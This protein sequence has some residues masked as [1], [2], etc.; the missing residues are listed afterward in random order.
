M[1]Q[2]KRKPNAININ[3]LPKKSLPKQ[4]K[5]P[6]DF[7]KP[8]MKK[9]I[10]KFSVTRSTPPNTSNNNI[11]INTHNKTNTPQRII[12]KNTSSTQQPT[13]SAK[14]TYIP[15][16]NNTGVTESRKPPKQIASQIQEKP[17]NHSTYTQI[18]P[19][20]QT[21][22]PPSKNITIAERKKTP[23]IGS[24][25]IRSQTS[26]QNS[27]DITDDYII[28]PS[29][30]SSPTIIV[31]E[32]SYSSPSI[33]II[34]HIAQASPSTIKT[35][36]NAQHNNNGELLIEYLKKLFSPR[37]ITFDEKIFIFVEVGKLTDEQLKIFQNCVDTCQCNSVLNLPDNLNILL[38]VVM[39]MKQFP[40]LY[41]DIGRDFV[42][43]ININLLTND[44]SS[45][46]LDSTTTSSSL[47]QNKIYLKYNGYTIEGLEILKYI[48]EKF[49]L[50]CFTL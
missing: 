18:K 20:S 43:R 19:I 38:Q 15:N 44:R 30:S 28:L 39:F 25:R 13:S 10:P 34:Q 26:S 1:E 21:Q 22:A 40:C 17:V 11:P 37:K 2:V 35:N 14:K 6:T 23:E 24:S 32:S 49:M 36:Q 46:T 29:S 31:P 16:S 50:D 48:F 3:T 5:I 47:A 41:V 42:E 8:I 27:S 33:S 45:N 4:P 7:P 9:T 12:I